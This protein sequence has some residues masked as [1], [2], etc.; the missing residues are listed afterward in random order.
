MILISCIC[1]GPDPA[2]PSRVLVRKI[3]K[4]REGSYAYEETRISKSVEDGNIKPRV[5]SQVS[6]IGNEFDLQK[7]VSNEELNMRGAFRPLPN[8]IGFS[9]YSRALDSGLNHVSIIEGSMEKT[10]GVGWVEWFRDMRDRRDMANYL[11][12][13]WNCRI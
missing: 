11:K 6:K 5:H 9:L 3:L 1:L 12:M 7:H 2:D 10:S 8:L 4:L 13:R